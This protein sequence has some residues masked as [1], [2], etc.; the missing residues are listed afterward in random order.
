M[1]LFFTAFIAGLLTVLAPCVLPLLPIIIGGSVTGDTKDKK[2]PVI[3]AASLAISIIIFTLLLKVSTV[4]INIPPQ[5]ITYF[6]G[7][8]II[9][10]GIV[11]LFP[12][13]YARVIGSL[14]IEAAAQKALGKGFNTKGDIAGPII[15]GAALGPVFSS[16]SPV[17]AYI[18]ATVLPA[19]FAQAMAYMVSYVLGLAVVL[20]GIGY[21][22]QSFI[23]R[24]KFAANPKGKFQKIVAILF[25]IVG[26]G[27]ATGYSVKFQTYVSEHTPFNFDSLSRRLL[28]S[29]HRKTDNSKLFNIT[30]PVAAP[31]FTGITGWVNSKPLTMQQLRGKVVLVD[32]WTYTCI[33]CIRNNPH[34]EAWYQRYKDEG[35][36]IVGVEAPEFSYEKVLSNVQKA[37]KD[38]HIT[39]PVAIDASL[40]TWNAYSN[41][42]WPAGYLIDASGQI[43]NLHEGEGGYSE[44]E[45]AIRQL[46]TDNGHDLSNVKPTEQ[47]DTVPISQ[48]QTPETYFGFDRA[49]DYEGS[50]ALAAKPTNTFKLPSQLDSHSWALGGKWQVD[51]D[52]ITARGNSTLRFKLSSKNVYVVVG[53]D[54]PASVGV[55][56]N[57]K[58][59]RSTAAGSDVKNGQLLLHGQQLYNLIS[60]PKFTSDQTVELSVPDGVILNTFTFGS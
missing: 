16:C 21:Y 2:R 3:I 24:I 10:L 22:G 18:L 17:Y 13:L 4:L 14:K 56:L 33:N 35:F 49:S 46:I 1:L 26:L 12:G 19:N 53:S 6:S 47:S 31:D 34:L 5:S 41:Q 37:V 59:I 25:I 32:F 20:L 42:S 38:Q 29:S 55:T 43:R 50:P 40:A 11:T 60:F 9:A 23:S 57:G 7:G 15:I 58:P 54:A 44:E 36:V 30:Q 8:I 51:G 39:Y 52:K 45:K 48:N 27:V 28:P